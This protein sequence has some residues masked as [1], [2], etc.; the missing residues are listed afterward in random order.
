MT[1]NV[2]KMVVIATRRGIYSALYLG[3]EHVRVKEMSAAATL[4][5]SQRTD[6]IGA[7]IAKVDQ[8]L[9]R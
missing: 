8:I 6:D 4:E 2:W 1:H 7:I 9:N 3:F 5:P